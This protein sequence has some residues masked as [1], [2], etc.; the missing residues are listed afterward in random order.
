MDTSR[1]SCL[2]SCYRRMYVGRWWTRAR[3]R[4]FRYRLETTRAVA[5]MGRRDPTGAPANLPAPRRAWSTTANPRRPP[6]Q[7]A[8][9]RN[10]RGRSRTCSATRRRAR[11]SVRAPG[12][13]SPPPAPRTPRIYASDRCGSSCRATSH[14]RR[15]RL[16]RRR[17][18][19]PTSSPRAGSCGT[20]T[21]SPRSTVSRGFP[22]IKRRT[23][24]GE[25]SSVT[26]NW[27]ARWSNWYH[28]R[29]GSP[30][31][32]PSV[33]PRRDVRPGRSSRRSFTSGT[34][35]GRRRMCTLA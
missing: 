3:V 17:C 30:P 35:P 34:I 25:A 8:P 28:P 12:R 22:G 31:M 20:G 7:S 21:P 26:S 13:A 10:P 15:T 6:G 4:G 11:R 27:A 32:A 16:R 19:P 2:T 24:T 5:R 14:T 29:T 9:T 18:P 33:C 1:S 23:S